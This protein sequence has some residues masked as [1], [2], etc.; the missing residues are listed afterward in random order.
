MQI[1]IGGGAAIKAELC[2]IRQCDCSGSSAKAI[3]GERLNS[4]VTPSALLLP[5]W[6]RK[7]DFL[8]LIYLLSHVGSIFPRLKHLLLPLTF[9]LFALYFPRFAGLRRN[10]RLMASVRWWSDA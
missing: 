3:G 1:A 8:H 4:C 6:C 7:P 2:G 5:N 10:K 9:R